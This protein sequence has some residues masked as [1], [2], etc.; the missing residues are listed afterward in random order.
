VSGG[1][2]PSAVGSVLHLLC[3]CGTVLHLRSALDQRDS[4]VVLNPAFVVQL[5]S[6]FLSIVSSPAIA[7]NGA[8]PASKLGEVFQ[9]SGVIVFSGFWCSATSVR[10]RV[11]LTVVLTFSC[12]LFVCGVVCHLPYAPQDYPSQYHYALVAVLMNVEVA[13]PFGPPKVCVFSSESCVSLCVC[14]CVCVCV[15]VSGMFSTSGRRRRWW[16]WW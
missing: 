8:L 16:W 5:V 4:F 11:E 10:R 1:F 9:V 6:N 12:V 3:D 13:V 7:S 14:V 2:A 15:L